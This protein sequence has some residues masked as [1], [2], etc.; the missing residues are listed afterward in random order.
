MNH[1][2]YEEREERPKLSFFAKTQSAEEPWRTP[3]ENPALRS[4]LGQSPVHILLGE[5]F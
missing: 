5:R 2:E 4:I 3:G 1:E